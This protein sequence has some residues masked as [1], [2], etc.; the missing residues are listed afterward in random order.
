MKE[1]TLVH[2]TNDRLNPALLIS[3]LSSIFIQD[4][5]LQKR[6]IICTLKPD[7]TNLESVLE[8]FL[9]CLNKLT[10]SQFY[11]EFLSETTI[12]LEVYN[13]EGLQFQENLLFSSFTAS[14][15][16]E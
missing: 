15:L 13:S 16:E 9:T 8:S 12:L 14:T 3:L 6:G 10:E 7:I 1:L 2:S 4:F 5:K 11:F